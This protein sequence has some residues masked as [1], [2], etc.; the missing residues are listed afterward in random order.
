MLLKGWWENCSSERTEERTHKRA[1]EHT[2]THTRTEEHTHNQ[3][4]KLALVNLTHT[5]PACV[6]MW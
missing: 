6:C 2:Q 5:D 1:E 3:G 4:G